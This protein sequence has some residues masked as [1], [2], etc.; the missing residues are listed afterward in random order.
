MVN[1]LAFSIWLFFH[2]VHVTLTSIDQV[3]GNDSLKVFVKMYYDDFLLDYI[4]FDSSNETVKA[5]TV[6]QLIPEALMNNYIS[7]KVTIIVNNKELKG[8]LLNLDLEDNEVRVNLLY[9]SVRKPKVITVRNCIMTELYA[10]QA[11]MMIVH[12]NDFEEG[13]KLTQVSKE[14]TFNLKRKQKRETEK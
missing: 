1:I 5:L 14:Q 4:L 13:I 12:V 2:P 6:N 3:R 8:K 9:R 7:E 10:D 11:N